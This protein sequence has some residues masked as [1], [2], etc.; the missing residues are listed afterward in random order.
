VLMSS[1]IL[2]SENQVEIYRGASKIFELE[3]L[4]MNNNP[5]NLTGAR[6]IMTVKCAVS[7]VASLIQKDSDVGTSQVDIVAPR[8]GKAEI[9]FVPS[10]T[11]TLDAGSYIFDVWVVLSSGSR[12]PVILPSVFLVKAGVT[13]LT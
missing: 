1:S 8:E 2:G 10:D 5:V 4:D 6:V 9:K 3:V 11:Q 7:A 12:N 13:V